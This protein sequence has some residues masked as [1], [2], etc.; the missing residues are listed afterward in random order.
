MCPA[1]TN[2]SVASRGVGL[3]DA[4]WVSLSQTR[5]CAVRGRVDGG[6]SSWWT[7]EST[8]PH[9]EGWPPEPQMRLE[10]DSVSLQASFMMVRSPWSRERP[11]AL[12]LH[13][14]CVLV[15]RGNVGT[16]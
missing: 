14:D 11:P 8:D 13:W 10:L 12:P 6:T 2:L 15:N 16:D 3:A 7:M 4:G 1:F 5:E 9:V